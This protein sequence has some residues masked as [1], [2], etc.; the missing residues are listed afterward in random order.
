M[1]TK[2][3]FYVL[4]LIVGMVMFTSSCNNDE[5]MND[6]ADNQQSELKLG[7]LP[8]VNGQGIITWVAVAYPDGIKRHFTIHC[9]TMF[10]GSVKGNGVIHYIGG[11]VDLKFD[12]NCMQVTGNM[13]TLSGIV[14]SHSTNESYVGKGCWVRLIDNGEG[15][16]EG[17]K[18]II[19]ALAVNL[20]DYVDCSWNVGVNYYEIEGGNIQVKP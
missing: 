16:T 7:N 18:D 9:N 11:E 4:A 2:N 19:S 20:Q 17:M 10:D 1:K 12:I 3:L 15:N 8:S 13:A 5:I 6:E 14:T